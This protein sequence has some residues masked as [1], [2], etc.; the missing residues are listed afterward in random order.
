MDDLGFE[1]FNA[2]I[3]VCRSSYALIGQKYPT[4]GPPLAEV[5]TA[6]GEGKAIAVARLKVV[7]SFE[8]VSHCETD[9]A[10]PPMFGTLEVDGN[11]KLDAGC[12]YRVWE[13]PNAA[14]CLG[15]SWVVVTGSSNA[16]LMWNSLLMMLA[17]SEAGLMRRGRFGGAHL[18]DAVIEDGVIIHY[19]TVKSWL[20]T[21]DQSTPSGAPNETECRMVYAETLAKAP[22]HSPNRIRL[23]MFLSFYWARTGTALDL[24]EAQDAWAMSE[25]SILVQVVAWYVVC[26]G[27]KFNGCHRPNLIDLP[28]DEVATMFTNEMEPVLNRMLM[29]CS[30][31]GR[32]G[33]RGCAVATNS[34]TNAGSPLLDMFLRFNALVTQAMDAKKTDSFRYLD[35]FALGASMPD[36]TLDGHGSQI[37]QLWTW[38]ALLGGF[39]SSS[40]AA[41]GSQVRFDGPLCWRKTALW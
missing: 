36:E 22:A 9:I 28:E 5:H 12:R 7:S 33:V 23:T 38:Q 10:E 21:C 17:P 35:I 29:F 6:A 11:F 3:H 30:P 18:L 27:I 41:T 13:L 15:G 16:L 26:N 32:A 4:D 34:F 2:R 14:A 19:E 20:D 8:E 24:I 31:G 25:V 39:C 40:S 1:S 37:L